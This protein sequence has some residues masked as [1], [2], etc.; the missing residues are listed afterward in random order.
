M[1]SVLIENLKDAPYRN[2]YQPQKAQLSTSRA[3]PQPRYARSPVA[4][5]PP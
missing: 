5:N 3:A 1:L 4:E 2:Q